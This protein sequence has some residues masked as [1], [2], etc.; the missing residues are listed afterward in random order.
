M[1]FIKK[2]SQAEYKVKYLLATCFA[3]FTESYRNW[4]ICKIGEKN[5]FTKTVPTTHVL[6]EQT[7]SNMFW[8]PNK[9]LQF[10]EHG[11]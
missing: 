4:T 11:I 7:S 1:A 6:R 8:L 5:V 2:L 10:N 9:L 3:L